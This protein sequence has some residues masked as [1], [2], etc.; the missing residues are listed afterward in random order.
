MSLRFARS[1]VSLLV[2][3]NIAAAAHAADVEYAYDEAGRLVGVMAPDGDAAQYVYDAAGNITEIR[4]FSASVLSLIEFQ[5][6]E[7]PIGTQVTIWGSGFSTTAS[8]NTVTFNGVA[9]TVNAATKN[10]L[11]VAVP[12]GASSGSV[13]VTVSATTATGARPFVVITSVNCAGRLT[14]LAPT[15]AAA[16]STITVS[17]SGFDR[18]INVASVNGA[19]GAVQSATNTALT[20]TVPAGA[21]SGRVTVSTSP[22]CHTQPA[23]DLFVPP[24]PYTSTDIGATGRLTINGPAVS[25][26]LASTKK[27]LFI[28]DG[29]SREGAGVYATSSTLGQYLL[30][31]RSPDG[32]V[33]AS[34]SISTA[35]GSVGP[36]RLPATG[37]YTVVVNP[38]TT[39]GGSVT[40]QLGGPDLSIG[41]LSA[42]TVTANQN[43][44][45]NIPTT[46]T[47]TNS[48]IATAGPSWVD[49]AYVAPEAVLPI[50]APTVGTPRNVP[51][52]AGA[53]YSVNQTYVITGATPGA[54]TLFIQVD[55]DGIGGGDLAGQIAETSEGNNVASVSI[56]LPTYS[57]L[58]I[59]NATVG[60]IGVAQS[61]AYTVPVSFTVTNLGTNPAIP[62]WT[63]RVFLSSSGVLDASS[64]AVAGWPRNSN[65]SGGSS[66]N[67]SQTL[68]VTGFQPGSYTLFMK[69]DSHPTLAGVLKE[70]DESNNATAGFSVTLPTLPD[71]VISNPVIGTITKN[72]NRWNIPVTFTV[73]NNGGS[74]AMPNWHDFAFLSAN[75]VLDASSTSMGSAFRNTSLAPNASYSVSQ[76]FL[77]PVVAPGTYT[78]FIKADGQGSS[79]YLL[80]SN[81]TNNATVGLTVTLN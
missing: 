56:N 75:G 65:L 48:G 57:D 45:F 53:S 6:K 39:T 3:L 67:V 9:A 14:G 51:L 19:T 66:Y 15:I 23:G 72:S 33:L 28:F 47:V 2:V 37:G 77:T 29:S 27:G 49:Y 46:F 74:T 17:G 81:E 58:S 80:E 24:S 1:L 54:R 63:D 76:T 30:E 68:N 11:V 60:T 61:G 5:P 16:G 32:A 18:G 50:G 35:S 43:G 38:Q 52:N 25:A 44:S 4:R 13:A 20:F 26:T 64:T 78:V 31:I 62:T 12:S 59:S 42:G 40:L 22:S 7:G 55:S 79:G 21:T 34:K 69:A 71:L 10:K 70:A 73:T 41:S 8:Q 36:V